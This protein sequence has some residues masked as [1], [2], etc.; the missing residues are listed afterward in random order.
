MVGGLPPKY[1]DFD[2]IINLDLHTEK[3]ILATVVKGKEIIALCIGLFGELLSSFTIFME[4]SWLKTV[5]LSISEFDN[6]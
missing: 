4:N 5:P 1:Y 3:I 6:V 2:L